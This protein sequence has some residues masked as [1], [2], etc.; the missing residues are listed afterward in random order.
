MRPQPKLRALLIGLSII[1]LTPFA[2]SATLSGLGTPTIDG[3]I[4][5]GEWDTAAKVSFTVNVPGGM[6][7]GALLFMNDERNL[8][9]AVQLARTFVD[10]GDNLIRIFLD[11]NNSFVRDIGDDG[12]WV[13]VATQLSSGNG[14]FDFYVAACPPL[15]CIP[16]DV[17]D[18]GTTD[19]TG[20]FGNNGTSSVFELKHPLDSGDVIHDVSL[21]PGDTVGLSVELVIGS[22][23][24][25]RLP[26]GDFRSFFD[27]V[28]VSAVPEASSL[29]L[30]GSGLAGLVGLTWRRQRRDDQSEAVSGWKE[31][32]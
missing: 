1:L 29:L 23:G 15:L 7:P 20:R 32:V 17:Q 26:G 24:L 3:F 11:R 16:F 25:T 12:I 18:S 9:F 22:I 31:P 2:A 19:G 10:A 14:F 21:R 4:A 28:S 6:S 27:T 8:Y 5:T 30:V 13:D